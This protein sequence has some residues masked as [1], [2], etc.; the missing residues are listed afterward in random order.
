MLRPWAPCLGPGCPGSSEGTAALRRGHT[1]R[2]PGEPRGWG[3]AHPWM[4]ALTPLLHLRAHH[5]QM[6]T[7]LPQPLL[8]RPSDPMT[9]SLLSVALG[10]PLPVLDILYKWNH[11]VCVHG[12]ASQCHVVWSIPRRCLRPRTATVWTCHSPGPVHQPG[13]AGFGGAWSPQTWGGRGWVRRCGRAPAPRAWA[14][15]WGAGGRELSPGADRVPSCPQ[16]PHRPRLPHLQRAVH[17]RAVCRSGH[18]DPLL[19]GM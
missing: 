5:P 14:R 1:A 2:A 4:C 11:T 8:S 18:R 15:V 9:A 3:S 7:P 13:T 19:D 16:L 12:L 6:E 17:H 10:V